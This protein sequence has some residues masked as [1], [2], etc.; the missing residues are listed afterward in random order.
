MPC[1][2][3]SAWVSAA[4]RHLTVSVLQSALAV[5]VLVGAYLIIAFERIDRTIAALLGAAALIAVG[6]LNRRE[7]VGFIDCN[8]EFAFRAFPLMLAGIAVAQTYLRWRYF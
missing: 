4:R 6:V 2:P 7:V 8:M 5:V 3:L 1:A